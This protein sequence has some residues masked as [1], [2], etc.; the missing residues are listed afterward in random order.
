MGCRS[1]WPRSNL[2]FG[3]STQEPVMGG[4]L[5]ILIYKTMCLSSL[6]GYS[7][8]HNRD[9]SIVSGHRN[10]LRQGHIEEQNGTERGSQHGPILIPIHDPCLSH[11]TL[12]SLIDFWH[13]GPGVC[14][15]AEKVGHVIILSISRFLP[16][17]NTK[18]TQ[19]DR[20]LTNSTI[21]VLHKQ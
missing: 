21:S 5:T 18:N 4:Q 15:S 12:Q 9:S 7:V 13:D 16:E 20:N 19:F 6:F 10:F 8:E 14:R 17:S 11:C 3:F 1:T 2:F